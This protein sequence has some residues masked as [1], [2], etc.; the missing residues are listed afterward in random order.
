MEAAEKFFEGEF[1]D[2]KDEDGDSPMAATSSSKAFKRLAVRVY[3]V[4]HKTRADCANQTP[5]PED[6]EDEDEDEDG[7]G[8]AED[9]DGTCGASRA[10]DVD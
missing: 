3:S 7:D 4:P 9:D 10:R 2:V 1:A 8:E 6:G 5:E